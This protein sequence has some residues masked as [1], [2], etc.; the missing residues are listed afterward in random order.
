MAAIVGRYDSVSDL[1]ERVLDAMRHTDDA[2]AYFEVFRY[3]AAPTTRATYSVLFKH[4]HP[5]FSA[6]TASSLFALVLSLYKPLEQDS[7]KAEE[8]PVDLW[9]I[10]ALAARHRVLDRETHKRLKQKLNS[11]MHIWQKV[12]R[13]RHRLVAHGLAGLCVKDELRD[14]D[15][16]SKHC[17]ELAYAYAEVLNSIAHAMGIARIDVDSTRK[18]MASAI[19]DLFSRLDDPSE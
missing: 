7:P 4:F 15:L 9:R 2:F 12:K 11:V 18:T 13:L 8:E 6:I 14:A 16:N 5:L 3:F 17:R 10:L 1:R 19:E